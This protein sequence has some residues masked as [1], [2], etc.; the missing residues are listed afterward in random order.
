MSSHCA[1]KSANS[2]LGVAGES[3]KEVR[4]WGARLLG[5]LGNLELF[6]IHGTGLPAAQHRTAMAMAI[7]LVLSY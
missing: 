1:R 3:E 2:V 4:R 6:D 7:Q 5:T